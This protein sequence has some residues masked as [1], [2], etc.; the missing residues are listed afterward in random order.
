MTRS[1]LW[2]RLSLV[3]AGSLMLAVTLWSAYVFTA[4]WLR[5]RCARQIM[6]LT[7]PLP[8]I[9]MSER[10]QGVRIS[11]DH[12][13]TWHSENVSFEYET[14]NED[15]SFVS[16][17]SAESD[18]L[19]S[20]LETLQKPTLRNLWLD[21]LR[22]A[23]TVAQDF[24]SV[25]ASDEDRR[26]Q[27][28]RFQLDIW[29]VPSHVRY[30]SIVDSAGHQVWLVVKPKSGEQLDV[31]SQ[32]NPGK[33]FDMFLLDESG[34]A[35]AQAESPGGYLV[36]KLSDRLGK[37]DQLV[38]GTPGISVRPMK[39]DEQNWP[40]R[41]QDESERYPGRLAVCVIENAELKVVRDIVDFGIPL[42][43]VVP[44]IVLENDRKDP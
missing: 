23:P 29:G 39:R 24:P 30:T 27:R 37:A 26:V 35:F 18:L 12:G 13:R 1:R 6:A 3:A 5:V 34:Q 33:S 41:W 17:W 40:E 16:A 22:A 19:W 32:D 10:P 31:N 44:A 43:R 25:P 8:V 38:F 36:G 7:R 14:S 15:V 20:H 9:R 2:K 21:L 4:I 28:V 42:R 11:Y